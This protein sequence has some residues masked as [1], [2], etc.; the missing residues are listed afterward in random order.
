MSVLVHS[1]EPSGRGAVPRTPA[2]SGASSSTV[3]GTASL[4][5][6]YADDLLL[7]A[8]R[9]CHGA[10]ARRIWKP[11]NVATLGAAKPSQVVH[12]GISRAVYGGLGA[13]FKGAARAFDAA[14][15]RGV[16]PRTEDHPTGRFI[17]STV[18]GLIGD[19]LVEE[20]PD[21]A[22]RMAVRLDDAD[23]PAT[24][25]ALATAFPDAAAQVVVFVHGLMEHD[26]HWRRREDELPSYGDALAATG[27]WTPVHLR[28]NT[29]LPLKENGIAL[30]GLLDQ[31]VEAWPVGVR[32]LA[33][34]GHS[35]GGLIIRAACAV[36]TDAREP[37]NRLVTD[38]V[39]LGTPNLGAP[40][41]KLVNAG[42][43]I[44]GV[45][46]EAAPFG[47]IL[48]YRSHG[49][50]DLR[51]GLAGDV[52]HLPHARYRLVSATIGPSPYHPL[53]LALGDGLVM[54][55]SAMGQSP[56][57]DLFPEASTLHLGSAHHFDLLNHPEVHRKLKEW[58][59]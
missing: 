44:L 32:R 30:A 34:V 18:H 17:V 23:V 45:L 51:R 1:G 33:L 42:S 4:A 35:M 47:R 19:R 31:L 12:D 48:D 16:G 46:P 53:S 59:A 26:A 54:H 49:I 39:L 56:R 9:D 7:G 50:L 38:V 58:L 14:D 2:V 20:T 43:R 15:R 37:W 10:V 5:A 6:R 41:E 52:Q 40:L 57:G 25:D 28:V 21:S 3:F 8:A 22:I 27:D 55:R 24:P 13:G 11:L 36:T 29:G